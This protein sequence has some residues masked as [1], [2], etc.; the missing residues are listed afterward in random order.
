MKPMRVSAG[1]WLV[2][3]LTACAAEQ[4]APEPA[5]LVTAVAHD[6]QTLQEI[7]VNV[8]TVAML[9]TR[10]SADDDV[11]CVREKTTGS[12]IATDRCYTRE[13]QRRRNSEAQEWLRSGGL[14]GS[15]SEVYPIQ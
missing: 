13:Q 5:L 11:I 6:P 8:K 14:S 12:H 9:P 7:K 3:L 4:P 1:L 10:P 15:V 2:I